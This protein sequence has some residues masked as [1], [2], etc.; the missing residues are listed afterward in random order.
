MG[1]NGYIGGRKIG[2]SFRKSEANV[3]GGV[4]SARGTPLPARLHAHWTGAEVWSSLL[5][6][7][8]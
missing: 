5:K 6:P 3:L 8:K 2:M 1:A 7:A 4:N